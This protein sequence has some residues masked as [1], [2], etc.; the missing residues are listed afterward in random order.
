MTWNDHDHRGEYADDRHDH[1]LDY[2]EKHHRHYDDESTVRGLRE[3]LSR[4]EERIRELEDGLRGVLAQI[5]VFDRL[6]PTC[7][8]CR[9]TAADRQTTRGPACSRLRRR[10]AGRRPRSGPAGDLGLRRGARPAAPSG[11]GPGR[12]ARTRAIRPRPRGR[13]RGRHVGAPLLRDARGLRARSV[14]SDFDTMVRAL[15]RWTA[16]HDPHVRA[17]VELLIEHETWIRRADFQR[18]C[19]E[20]GRPRGV[21]QLAQGPRVRGCGLDSVDQRDGR[22]RPGRGDRREPL[23]VLDHGAGQLPDDRPGG[24]PRA[25]GGPVKIR[26][27]GTEEECAEA[28]DLLGGVMVLQSVSDPYPD[29]GRS[30]LVRVYVEAVPRGG[31]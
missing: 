11:R 19:I 31:R 9:D 26:L 18:A 6:R 30:V 3:D 5:R 29:R 16:S 1:D 24:R 25:R 15:R 12:R 2:A 13:R 20:R 21:D 23:Q 22:A 4:A 7:A 17:A 14:M 8:I 10:P 27:H 28:V